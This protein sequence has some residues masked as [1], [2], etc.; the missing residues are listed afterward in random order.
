MF[1]LLFGNVILGVSKFYKSLVFI[2]FKVLL[3][4]TWLVELFW[5]IEASC[6]SWLRAVDFA[7]LGH[8]FFHLVF[9]GVIDVHL[10]WLSLLH[11]VSLHQIHFLSV[12]ISPLHL[13][14]PLN[15]VLH[16]LVSCLVLRRS[17]RFLLELLSFL[18]NFFEISWSLL[19]IVVA[20]DLLVN[21]WQSCEV[22]LTDVTHG[23]VAW[24][25]SIAVELLRC[26]VG[27]N[28]ILLLV[29]EHASVVG[30]FLAHLHLVNS[31]HLLLEFEFVLIDLVVLLVVL[32]D[33]NFAILVHHILLI[34]NPIVWLV[35]LHLRHPLLARVLLPVFG[36]R[37]HLLILHLTLQLVHR[38]IRVLNLEDLLVL[39][40]GVLVLNQIHS[41]PVNVLVGT[42][43]ILALVDVLA[44]EV[45][46]CLTL[47]LATHYL[48]RI[49]LWLGSDDLIR[50]LPLASEPFQSFIAA[51]LY[52]HFF[53]GLLPVVV[54]F[55]NDF[56]ILFGS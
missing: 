20:D 31:S 28:S 30:G 53:L 25:R 6:D 46:N 16:C 8:I 7:L 11:L 49:I 39:H 51:L 35:E 26:F 29:S 1:L 32:V 4:W 3:L 33:H 5:L 24:L 56:L 42:G 54:D 52:R 47:D 18:T 40:L 13:E 22:E 27:L 44:L 38:L 21:V 17:H 12:P 43:N 10:L 2:F 15:A 9:S 23:I 19:T 34:V 14:V 36:V 55:Q 41:L 37:N 50:Q 45:L 48:P